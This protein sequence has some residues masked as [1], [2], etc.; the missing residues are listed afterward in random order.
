MDKI[1]DITDDEGPFWLPGDPDGQE[2]YDR[3]MRV[4]Q[5]G[6]HGAKRIYKGQCDLLGDGP[7]GEILKHMAEQEEVHYQTFNRLMPEKKVRPSV[8]AP[9][10]HALGYALGA[11]TAAM[12]DRAAMA[13]TVAVE[14][15]IDAHY[16]TQLRWL[17]KNNRD[18][19]LQK[20][21]EQFQIE[22]LEHRDIGLAFEAEYA[23]GY[24]MLYTAIH[25]GARLAIHLA[26]KY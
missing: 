9:L 26:E 25:G 14:E 4:D 12:G 24:K 8:L 1:T 18:E 7:N 2:R 6:E 11:G 23:P 3:M 10:W 13:C 17:K 15:A 19:E 16:E 20:L 21:I 22:E 5:A